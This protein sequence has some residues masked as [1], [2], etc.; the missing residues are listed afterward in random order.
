MHPSVS[1][2][3]LDAAR[4]CFMD[5]L[6]HLAAQRP[7]EA[8]A[9]FEAS[10]RLVP[11]RVS[12]LLNLAAARLALGRADAAQDAASQVLSAEP[13]NAEAWFHRA[14]AE[15]MRQ[16][17]DAAL[18]AFER[19]AALAPGSAHP[20]FRHGQV[21]QG[22]G[23]DAQALPSY[24]RAVVAD[25]AFAPAWTNLGT[26]LREQGRAADAAHAFRQARAHGADDELHG[27]YLAAVGA[28]AAP[29][30]A[31]ALYV[32]TLFDDYAEG[33][34]GHVVDVLDYRA[35]RV[36]ARALS[37]VAPGRTFARALDLGCGTGL[38]GALLRPVVGH[39]SGVDL[40]G[41]MLAQAEVGGAYDAL[42]RQ[43]VVEFLR[44]APPSSLDLVTAADVFIYVGDLSAA[45]EAVSRV[46]AEAG[47]FAFSV[48][49]AARG[50]VSFALQASLRY[51]HSE[52]YLRELARLHGLDVRHVE[53]G[54]VRRDQGR[55]VE[56]LFML[57]TGAGSAP[58]ADAASGS[59]AG[60]A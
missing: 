38:C 42:A 34:A 47:V 52:A 5:G 14:N 2:T 17:T 23:R 49:L 41:R 36:L 51:A 19:A 3:T 59:A 40:S 35:H 39:L 18:R 60:G 30:A 43:D 45:F 25:P 46:L 10:L 33:F 31:P 7:A 16:R 15:A 8:E 27:Y 58:A 12:T 24:E 54:A 29:P 4:Q 48:E 13:D 44:A 20:W 22:L 32:E 50:T 57:L 55:P 9:Q 56:G 21:L 26:L 37:A 28:G 1:S 11:G 53:R 6:A